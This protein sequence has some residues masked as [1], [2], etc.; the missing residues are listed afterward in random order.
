MKSKVIALA[1]AV[2]LGTSPCSLPVSA[3]PE[4]V[5]ASDAESDELLQRTY[6]LMQQFTA[7]HP[8]TLLEN[9]VPEWYGVAIRYPVEQES[10]ILSDLAAVLRENNIPE[11]MVAYA[12][13]PLSADILKGDVDQNGKV[14]IADAI[15]L[16]RWLAEDPITVTAGGLTA[17]DLTGDG[18]VTSEDAV[19]L[20]RRLA[21]VREETEQS[22]EGHSVDLLSGYARGGGVVEDTLSVADCQ[23]AA[24]N[25]AAKLLK[26]LCSEDSGNTLI[27]PMSVSLALGMT[28][29]G[30][31]GQT[32]DEMY[33]LLAEN[34]EQK[35]HFNMWC[36]TW[37]DYTRDFNAK[38]LEV[39]NAIWFR[40]D[41]NR[42]LVPDAFRKTVADYYDAS[43]YK[44]PFDET[45]L[46]DVNGWV[47]EKT[48]GMIPD[49]LEKADP[50]HIMYLLNALAFEAE[51]EK[52]YC[53]EEV[54]PGLFTGADG[55]PYGVD[56][57]YSEESIYLESENATGFMKPFA[58]DNTSNGYCFA[59][60]LP[61]EGIS[62]DEY[63][64]GLD[65]EEI[66]AL[67]RNQRQANVRTAMPK[68]SFEWGKSLKPA[69]K[70]LGMQSAFSAEDADFSGLNDRATPENPTYIEDV[71]HKTFIEV[72]PLGAKAGA[73]TAVIM[74]NRGGPAK[75]KQVTLDRPFLFM[76]VDRACMVP[77]FIGV[78]RQTGE[79]VC[80]QNTC[81]PDTTT[82]A[83]STTTTTTEWHC[84]STP[85]QFS[86]TST[87]VYE[88]P[89][90]RTTAVAE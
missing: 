41:E 23:D 50:Q 86:T 73:A 6:T 14:E 68:F 53:K 19:S 4:T 85:E 69:L 64:A 36:K 28:A 61:N 22:S 57:M 66:A 49:I 76:I 87:M 24:Y 8:G 59:A 43:L 38:Q 27:S 56:M 72:G 1:A 70:A 74:V 17:A 32:Q 25:F 71:I 79:E 26:K 40:D 2:L 78:V 82:E 3:A 11:E 89:V 37:Q 15:M 58:H 29:N 65:A 55:F 75:M 39:A 33:A 77:V 7:D 5:A 83:E 35:E 62:I 16:A 90:I 12:P 42:I 51:W 54:R 52:E 30:A 80:V 67:L 20:L 13:L 18:L 31:K 34:L 10:A 81:V 60:V 48:H 9:I 63:I 88:N 21:G 47:N 84:I 44:A 45:T 46:S